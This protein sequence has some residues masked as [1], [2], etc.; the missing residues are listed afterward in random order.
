MAR[1][2]RVIS[3]QPFSFFALML[4]TFSSAAFQ[5]S[6]T[7]RTTTHKGPGAHQQRTKMEKWRL[8]GM[9]SKKRAVAK[10]FSPPSSPLPCACFTSSSRSS[11]LYPPPTFSLQFFLMSSF[12]SP[13]YRLVSSAC[14]FMFPFFWFGSVSCLRV[15]SL[16]SYF[17]PL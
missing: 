5:M 17:A 2:L 16:T 1:T 14:P 11:A 10:V 15:V 7:I 4:H 3:R 6:C 13:C 9:L 8:K 12:L